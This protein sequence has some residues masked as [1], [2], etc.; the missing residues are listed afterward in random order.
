MDGKQ[1]ISKTAFCEYATWVKV[2]ATTKINRIFFM[3]LFYWFCANI[4]KIIVTN[5][6]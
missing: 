4:V 2:D 5:R 1:V 3:L 6:T